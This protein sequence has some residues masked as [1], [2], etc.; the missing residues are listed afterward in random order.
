VVD[1]IISL[2]DDQIDNLRKVGIDR[3]VGITGQIQSSEEREQILRAFSSGHYLFCYVA[4][5][6]FQITRFREALRALTVVTPISLIAIDEAHCVSE[7]GHDFRTAYLNLGR[8]SREYC[9]LQGAVP[10]LMALT[11]TASKIVLKDVQRELTIQDFDAIITPKSFD[12]PELHFTV[13]TCKSTDK[14]DRIQGVMSRL[15]SDF[16]IS[17]TTF[18]RRLGDSS[19]CGLIFCPHVNGQF[20]VVS[21]AERLTRATG[22]EADFYSGGAPRGFNRS[23]WEVARQGAA[24]KFKR[25]QNTLLTCTKA[26]G[27]GIDKPNIRYTIHTGLPDSIESFYQEAGRAGRDRRRAECTIIISNDYP[28]RST[29]LLSPATPFQQIASFVSGMRWDE[30]DD[31]A[32]VLWFHVKA[33]KGDRFELSDIARVIESLGDLQVRKTIRLTP[34]GALA[35]SND[36][37]RQATEK[38][39]HRL[40]ILNVVDDY[41]VDYSSSEFTVTLSG[42]KQEEIARAFS[43]YAGSYQSGQKEKVLTDALLLLNEDHAVF[44]N[45]MCRMLVEFIYEHIE[46]AQRRS[47]NEMLSAASSA[48]T[49]EDLRARILNHLEHSEY[50]RG[51]DEVLSSPVGG[52]DA[53]DSFVDGI[54]SP[55]EATSLRGAVGRLLESYPDVPGLLLL[56]SLAEGLSRDS[57]PIVLCQSMESALVFAHNQYGLDIHT[58][59]RASANIIRGAMRKRES[60][61]QLM[62]AVLSW[63]GG[64]EHFIR[65]L[66]KWIPIEIAVFPAM[67]LTTALVSRTSNLRATIGG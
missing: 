63:E 20:G 45:D 13:L 14:T 52:L 59:A 42:A 31:I 40:V 11:G 47:L 17:S 32:R 12:R 48:K 4:P 46:L 16:G 34:T 61:E 37:Q 28:R 19:H 22:I 38:A 27:M 65:E 8:V 51:L 57:D 67:Q 7:W 10:P 15:P 23:E 60:A 64:R 6:R 39:L 62:A 1:P 3:T 44:V 49:G 43:Q 53:I 66:L 30:Q 18:F 2:I 21:I 36:K 9:K 35:D 29:E 58:I 5:E 24:R 25:N 26:F 54:V 55:N 33:F 56:R 41:T 50:D